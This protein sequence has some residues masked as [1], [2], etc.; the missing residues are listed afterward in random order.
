MDWSALR[1]PFLCSSYLHS[2]A[3]IFTDR[4]SSVL[5]GHGVSRAVLQ[6]NQMGFSP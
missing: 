3:I 5:M 1:V 4:S 6:V 2:S